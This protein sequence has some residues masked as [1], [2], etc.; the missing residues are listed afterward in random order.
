MLAQ[1]S[2]TW[3]LRTDKFLL[4]G[5]SG[6]GQFA[7]RFFY[8]HPSRL[9][10]ASIGAPGRITPPDTEKDWPAGVRDAAT[11]FGVE[12]APNF[13]EMAKVPVQFVV[14][15]RDVDTALLD[16]VTSPNAG[17]VGTR[18]ER[19]RWLRDRLAACGV[20]SELSIVKGVGHAGVKCLPVVEEWIK[21]LL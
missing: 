11:L 15:D 2:N 4:H 9:L 8:L 3:R 21:Q 18:V 6:G 17:E 20:Q 5:F 19:I 10:G 1:A 12:D 13:G 14:G 7:H 16:L